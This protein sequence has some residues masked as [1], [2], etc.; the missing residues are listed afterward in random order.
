VGGK[1]AQVLYRGRSGCCAG[2][3]QIR[4]VIP[5]GVEGCSVPLV[6]IIEGA[7]SNFTS[8]SIAPEGA[9]CSDPNGAS[10]EELEMLRS[11]GEIRSGQAILGRIWIESNIP[12]DDSVQRS[13]NAS[14]AFVGIDSAQS[15]QARNAAPTIGSCVVNQIP[16]APAVEITGLD[17]GMVSLS[18]PVGSFDLLQF[19]TGQH[20]LSFVP[21]SP[22]LP[23]VVNDGTLLEAGQY[24]HTGTGGADVGAFNVRMDLPTPIDWTN[25]TALDT[26]N[27]NQPLVINW[28]NGTPGTF[29][30]IIG[31]SGFARGPNGLVGAQF[32][33]RV[34]ATAGTFV[35][36]GEVVASLPVSLDNAGAPGGQLL[37]GAV[38]FG[39][40][41]QTNGIAFGLSFF[42]DIYLKN[43]NYR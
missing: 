35:V 30:Q 39:E 7:P 27:L 43:V 6:V 8:M 2:I 42:A 23:G 9:V 34:D 1:P 20:I 33:C 15:L 4:I 37:V 41:F 17:A 26:V 14:A 22:D 10:A 28:T 3:D 29:V 25:R 40:R 16:G 11:E 31:T 12:G 36:P 19:V 32:Q 38:G 13:D 18:G 24:T 21:G 5:E